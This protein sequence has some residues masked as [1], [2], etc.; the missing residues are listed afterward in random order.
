MQQRT[1]PEATTPIR[2]D[3]RRMGGNGLELVFGQPSGAPERVATELSEATPITQSK[4]TFGLLLI[5]GGE[6]V[7]G[8]SVPTRPVEVAEQLFRAPVGLMADPVAADVAAE[9]AA[10]DGIALAPGRQLVW[11]LRQ[12]AHDGAAQRFIG[13]CAVSPAL[14][15]VDVHLERLEHVRVD[16]TDGPSVALCRSL[17]PVRLLSAVPESAD[18]ELKLEP[19]AAAAAA[20]AAS[21]F[22]EPEPEPEPEAPD[23][24]VTISMTLEQPLEDGLYRLRVAGEEGEIWW[25][26][27][28][29][30]DWRHRHVREI[31]KLADADAD[32]FLSSTEYR[33]MLKA[34][35]VWGRSEMYT[36][37][38]WSL[39]WPR[40]CQHLG[41]SCTR[42]ISEVRF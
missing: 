24:A 28:G 3:S 5:G 22:T 21:E 26:V 41:A 34:L 31:F 17:G 16:E 37:E 13:K 2:V 7:R 20:A 36:E 32:G 8:L 38:R 12:P 11:W 40:I 42:G 39:T 25:R 29:C 10:A 30:A 1:F 19:G 18:K 6:V 15:L 9:S 4:G 14:A 33:Q 27:I 23:S 35:D